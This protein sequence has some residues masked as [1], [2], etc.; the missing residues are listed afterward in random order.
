MQS[1]SSLPAFLSKFF[2]PHCIAHGILVPPPGIKPLSPAAEARSSN[3]WTTKEAPALLI[4]TDR[5]FVVPE[6]RQ[7]SGKHR[8]SHLSGFSIHN[9]ATCSRNKLSL[10][11]LPA[12]NGYPSGENELPSPITSEPSVSLGAEVRMEPDSLLRW[13]PAQSLLCQNALFTH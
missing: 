8:K 13:D 6:A 5:C 2:W 4:A 7:V 3:H 11:L 1:C 12:L 9:L 10:H